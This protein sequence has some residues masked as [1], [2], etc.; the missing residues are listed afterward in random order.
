L[1]FEHA[2]LAPSMRHRL[3]LDGASLRDTLR[4]AAI[5]DTQI[6]ISFVTGESQAGSI[7]GTVRGERPGVPH[8]VTARRAAAGGAAFHADAA[9]DGS[10]RLPAVPPGGYTLEAYEDEDGNGRWS[11]GRAL[12]FRPSERFTVLRDTIRVRTRWETGG[13]QL[14]I[15]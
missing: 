2:L 3:C 11:P 12:P 10:F 4:G 8:R 7:A 6:C 15:R 13:V 1:R 14:R 5:A 9:Q